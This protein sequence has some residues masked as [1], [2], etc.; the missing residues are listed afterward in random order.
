M[1]GLKGSV[2]FDTEMS[3]VL[4]IMECKGFIVESDHP[5][6]YSMQY[7][8]AFND[9]SEWLAENG[10]QGNLDTDGHYEPYAGNVYGLYDKDRI[11]YEKMHKELIKEGKRQAKLP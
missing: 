3:K 4:A 6:A 2:D 1:N 11:S 5:Y 10:Y 9:V 7:P 8:A